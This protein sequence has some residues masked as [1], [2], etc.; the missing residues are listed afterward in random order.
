MRRAVASEKIP[1]VRL[2]CYA[3]GRGADP[4]SFLQLLQAFKARCHAGGMPSMINGSWY[5]PVFPRSYPWCQ[6]T[7]ISAFNRLARTCQRRMR[8]SCL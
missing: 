5:E 1:L 2:Q 6:P 8:R 4:H 7:P 3:E